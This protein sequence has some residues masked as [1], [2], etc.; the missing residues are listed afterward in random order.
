M[1]YIICHISY[2]L[3]CHI[4]YIMYMHELASNIKMAMNL[5]ESK[6]RYMI[7]FEVTIGDG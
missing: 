2:I 7:G 3:A 6:E 1:L 5:K 4:S